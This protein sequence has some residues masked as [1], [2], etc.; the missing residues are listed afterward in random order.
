MVYPVKFGYVKRR[1]SNNAQKSSL[2][3]IPHPEQ[4]AMMKRAFELA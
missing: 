1:E 4:Y 2:F 3:P